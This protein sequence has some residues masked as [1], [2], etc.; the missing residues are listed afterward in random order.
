VIMSVSAAVKLNTPDGRTH[1]C[2]GRCT[3][4]APINEMRSASLNASPT[5][6]AGTPA[7]CRCRITSYVS[8]SQSYVVASSSAQVYTGSLRRPPHLTGKWRCVPREALTANA[9][10]R[11]CHVRRR[12]ELRSIAD[13]QCH[14]ITPR[15]RRAVC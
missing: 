11:P 6:V 12:S 8:A 14:R 3:G 1:N 9:P 10:G 2:C 13:G 5:G 7:S 4:V 15:V